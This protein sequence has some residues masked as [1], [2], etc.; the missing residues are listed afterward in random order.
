MLNL[1]ESAYQLSLKHGLSEEAKLIELE[2]ER[3]FY[4]L[5]EEQAMN[6]IT[7][8]QT[9]QQVEENNLELV[10]MFK[11]TSSGFVRDNFENAIEDHVY[12]NKPEQKLV[13]T[14]SGNHLISK[15]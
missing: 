10:T 8:A 12:P 2:E 5:Q 7:S 11:N 3:L 13:K 4:L 6:T 14:N 1:K 9:G 15:E